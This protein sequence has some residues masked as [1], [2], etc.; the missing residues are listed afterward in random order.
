MPYPRLRCTLK[1]VVSTNSLRDSI[2]AS[3]DVARQAPSVHNSQPWRVNLTG[4]VLSVHIDWDR[5]VTHGDPTRR[6]TYMSL[7]IFTE[8]IITA[9]AGHN[10]LASEPLL[11][12]DHVSLYIRRAKTQEA[13]APNLMRSLVERTTDRSIYAKI[14]YPGETLETILESGKNIPAR[15]WLLTDEKTIDFFSRNTSKAISLAI[16]NPAFRDELSRFLVRPWSNKKV[17]ISVK[18]LYIPF[19]VAVA[20]PFI[21]RHGIALSLEPKLEYKRWASSSGIVCITTVGDLEQSWFQAGRKYMAVSLTI[22]SFGISQATSAALVEASTFHE[23]VEK[24]LGTNERLQAVIRFG[25]GKALRHHSPRLPL[26][27][28]LTETTSNL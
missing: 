12:N 9:C 23:D 7:G 4:N 11:A 13:S 16:S 24:L 22:E 28:I 25:K 26:E 14:S 21:L 2:F 19:L 10:L 5:A 17:G 3:I 6:Q 18:S 27:A 15:T 20:E 1:A 8:A